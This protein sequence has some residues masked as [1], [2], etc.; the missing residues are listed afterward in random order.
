MG[1]GETVR[2]TDGPFVGMYGTI[3]DKI[4]SRVVL[5]LVCGS[6]EFQVEI[7]RDWTIAAAPH[8]PPISHIERS[9][10]SQRLAGS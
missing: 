10:L 4:H 1:I 6:R 3:V 2:I 8:R 9:N 5:T 7:D